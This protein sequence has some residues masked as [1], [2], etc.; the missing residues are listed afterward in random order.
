MAFSKKRRVGWNHSA[1]RD[2]YEVL[3]WIAQDDVDNALSFAEQIEREAD[4]LAT[5]AERGR[6][7]PEFGRS[8]VRELLPKKYRLIYRLDER[9]VTIIAFVHGSRLLP[10]AGEFDF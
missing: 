1:S 8:D 2:L 6:V 10:G 3:E 9:S 5:L 7:V 4:S